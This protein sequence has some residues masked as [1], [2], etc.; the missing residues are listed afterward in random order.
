MESGLFL[1][2]SSIC[3]GPAMRKSM[4]LEERKVSEPQDK[5]RD[6]VGACDHRPFFTTGHVRECGLSHNDPRIRIEA[7]SMYLGWGEWKRRA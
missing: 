2:E 1:A 6:K 3:N 7:L 4:P 5:T